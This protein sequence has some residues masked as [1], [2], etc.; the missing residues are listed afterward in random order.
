LGSD[1]TYFKNIGDIKT[2]L[3]SLSNNENLINQLNDLIKTAVDNELRMKD[4]YDEVW[5]VGSDKAWDYDM[6]FPKDNSSN[7]SRGKVEHLAQKKTSLLTTLD[8]R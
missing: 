6:Y 4:S 7:L 8:I 1:Q 5:V 3:F 2:N